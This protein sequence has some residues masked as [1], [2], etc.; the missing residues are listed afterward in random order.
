LVRWSGI[1]GRRPYQGSWNRS[2]SPRKRER[3]GGCCRQRKGSTYQVGRRSPDWVKIKARLQQ[4]F[5]IGGFTEAKGSR[6]HFGALL[7]GAFRNGKL[8]YFGHSG[9]RFS[10]N[11]LKETV[12]RLKPLFTTKCPFDNPP[13]IPGGSLPVDV[14]I[15]SEQ[16]V[17]RDGPYR[18]KL[19]VFELAQDDRKMTVESDLSPFTGGT[20]AHTS[21][22]TFNDEFVT[23]AEIR[24]RARFGT[25]PAEPNRILSFAKSARRST[26]S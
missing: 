14:G 24:V 16:R 23:P 20:S 11:A 25:K 3:T 6:K 10:E 12:D 5:V 22:G 1:P 18:H 19:K 13:K 17:V 8:H 7:L 9:S 26:R 15:Q 2:I 4:E 21:S